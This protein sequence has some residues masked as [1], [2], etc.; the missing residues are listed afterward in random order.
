M[1]KEIVQARTKKDTKQKCEI[2][3]GNPVQQQW[4]V[5]A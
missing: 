2:A 3:K 5:C 1:L 4:S